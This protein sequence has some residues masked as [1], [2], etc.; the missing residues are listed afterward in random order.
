MSHHSI[1]SPFCKTDHNTLQLSWQ[2]RDHQENSLTS[3]SSTQTC[4]LR[5]VAWLKHN[6]TSTWDHSRRKWFDATY[7]GKDRIFVSCTKTNWN[8]TMYFKYRQ[9]PYPLELWQTFQLLLFDSYLNLL[10]RSSSLLSTVYAICLGTLPRK[11]LLVFS[12]LF[13][14]EVRILSLLISCRRYMWK[15]IVSFTV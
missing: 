8:S 2:L 4:T 11:K 15:V 7:V 3:N 13:K 12:I 9:L 1:K 6:N 14:P 10:A 5:E